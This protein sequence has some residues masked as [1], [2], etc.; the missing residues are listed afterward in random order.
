MSQK[1]FSFDDDDFQ[2]T[3][4]APKN[5]VFGDDDFFKDDFFVDDK[6]D[7]EQ[8]AMK[9]GKKSKKGK[10]K[11]KKWQIALIVFLLLIIGFIVYVFVAGDN[12]GPVY[13]DR[14][15]SL[16]AIDE[17]KFDAVEDT[18][19]AD[20]NINSANI[21][22]DCRIIKISIN[23]IDNTNSDTAIQLATNALHTLDDALGET[24]EEGS[25]YSNLLGT[26]NGRG[27]YNVE[28]VLTSN[29]DTNFPIFGTK[30]PTSDE[31]SFT[32]ANPVDQAATDRATS[33]LNQSGQ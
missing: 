22:V 32:G 28:F 4:E 1:R 10:F 2:N 24:K 31:I 16:I 30:Q 13:G 7:S 5:E 20:G 19:E 6:V 23:Y 25:V 11:L 27:Q 14:C 17:S 12:D 26:A 21:E 9:K 18:I 29:G 33:T 3:I 15:A 8:K